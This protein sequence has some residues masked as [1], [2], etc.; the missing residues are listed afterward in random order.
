MDITFEYKRVT[1]KKPICECKSQELT[2]NDIGTLTKRMAYGVER[3]NLLYTGVR[4]LAHIS[5]TLTLSPS[6]S[7]R[8][9][10]LH[11]SRSSK[12]TPQI[13]EIGGRSLSFFSPFYL[14]SWMD[15]GTVKLLCYCLKQPVMCVSVGGVVF[16]TCNFNWYTFVTLNPSKFQTDVQ[17]SCTKTHVYI[18]MTTRIKSFAHAYTVITPS[19]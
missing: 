6:H 10:C 15:T 14:F 1:I 2:E 16:S 7:K 18:D 8:L 12:K 9:A 19:L 4:N 17:Y 3:T 5:L 13:I 11:T